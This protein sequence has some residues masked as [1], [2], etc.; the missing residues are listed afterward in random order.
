MTRRPL[1]FCCATCVT[2]CISLA[3]SRVA[4][5]SDPPPP[6]T[7]PAAKSLD[8]ELLQGFDTKLSGGIDDK[9]TADTSKKP[10]EKST[11]KPDQKSTDQEPSDQ[12]APTK[13]TAAP[14]DP[15]DEQLENSLNGGEDLG[16]AGEDKNPLARIVVRMRQVQQRLAE[17]K[18]DS[19][20]QKEQ[21]RISEEL[22]SLIE[23][24][25]QQQ[26]Q[27][28]ASQSEQHQAARDKT[29][30]G[31]APPGKGPAGDPDKDPSKGSSSKVRPNHSERPDPAAAREAVKKELDRL[32]LPDKD[33]EEMLQG[34]PDEFLPG[35]ESSIEQYFQ[36]LIEQEDE[37]P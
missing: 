35:H 25:V 11:D 23:Q 4:G 31:N 16:S 3:V 1:S 28:Q 21:Q 8:D 14:V 26:Q 36:R 24:L 12:K 18:S 32:H 10:A 37:R 34:A 13:K 15:L 5:A 27:S 17:N 30:P 33:S 7:K 22:K 9:P 2:A 29:K 20:T 6:T 19:L